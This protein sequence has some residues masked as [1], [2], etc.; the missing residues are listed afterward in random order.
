MEHVT[1]EVLRAIWERA[2]GDPLHPVGVPSLR[3]ALHLTSEE[4]RSALQVLEVTGF[5]RYEG[6]ASAPI[7][8]R[9]TA[10]G[11]AQ[12]REG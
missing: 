2:N 1:A 8:V 7:T 4:L 12:G 10:Q 6:E 11:A 9:L 5:V 3:D